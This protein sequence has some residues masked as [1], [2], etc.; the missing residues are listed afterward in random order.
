[1]RILPL[2]AATP[3]D[4]VRTTRAALKNSE[5]DF[6][7]V[8]PWVYWRDMLIG[9]TVAYTSATFFLM[10]PTFSLVQAI[11][12][13]LAVFWLYR[14]GSLVHEVAHLGGHELTS[15][16]VAWNLLVGV[17]TLTPSTF[18]TGHHRDHHT[19]RIY[20]TPQDP[21]YVVQCMWTR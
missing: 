3:T 15:F 19:P 16:K 14:V 20:G 4:W 21:E 10:A 2:N 12:F 5:T 9:A 8:Q 7:R 13:L 18:F 11:S 6:H 17:P 1:M